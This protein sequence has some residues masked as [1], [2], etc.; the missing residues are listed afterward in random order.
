MREGEMEIKKKRIFK[1]GAVL[2]A[3]MVILWNMVYRPLPDT[4][5]MTALE[6]WVVNHQLPAEIASEL[7][8]D[9]LCD[10][11]IR[12]GNCS[13]KVGELK[14]SSTDTQKKMAISIWFEDSEKDL[15][16]VKSYYVQKNKSVFAIQM[17]KSIE[18]SWNIKELTLQSFSCF[19]YINR[20]G[21]YDKVYET[22]RAMRAKM[23]SFETEFSDSI[24][25]SGIPFVV[26]TSTFVPASQTVDTFDS[27]QYTY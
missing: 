3:L 17:K 21:E 25:F 26:L 9:I 12:M 1:S 22:E 18:C 24:L 16:Y 19:G 10:L 11:K 27:V 20:G 13:Y 7:P 4:D 14:D 15:A 23:G 8:Y 6:G 5:T 2:S